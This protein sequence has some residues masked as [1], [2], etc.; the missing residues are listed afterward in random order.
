[1]LWCNN[2]TV[3]VSFVA[4]KSASHFFYLQ[5]SVQTRCCIFFRRNCPN[6]S[7]H[8]VCVR[9][10][11][12]AEQLHHSDQR[13]GVLSLGWCSS[14]PPTDPLGEH[15]A[16][17]ANGVCSL[18][19]PGILEMFLAAK[20]SMAVMRVG[21]LSAFVLPCLSTTSK[22]TTGWD[23][24]RCQFWCKNIWKIYDDR[25]WSS[26]LSKNGWGTWLYASPRWWPKYLGQCSLWKWEW[27]HVQL[28]TRFLSHIPTR[29]QRA[30]TVDRT[31][32]RSCCKHMHLCADALQAAWDLRLV[33]LLI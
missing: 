28:Q 19:A 18:E 7:C 6:S 23:F 9:L 30:G 24:W 27:A 22:S 25:F 17:Q 3:H 31:G 12:F 15:Q 10:C 16:D 26:F 13:F 5:R 20:P 14:G 11:Q 8:A 32:D 4:D 33:D 29:L 2:E 21:P 1:M